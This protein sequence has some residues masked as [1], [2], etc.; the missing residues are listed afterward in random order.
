[1]PG[2]DSGPLFQPVKHQ[3]GDD[4]MKTVL[5]VLAVLTILS[6]AVA[7]AE[8]CQRNKVKMSC[9]A[10]QSWDAASQRCTPVVG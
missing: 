2:G 8:G 9:A 5:S 1:L 4:P 3:Q 10:G 6:P 7:M